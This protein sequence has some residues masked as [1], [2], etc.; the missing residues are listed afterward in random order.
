VKTPAKL[1]TPEPSP[2]P[3]PPPSP[4]WMG[5]HVY[6]NAS[7]YPY[8]RQFTMGRKVKNEIDFLTALIRLTKT[9]TDESIFQ[10]LMILL[11]HF[12]RDD[13]LESMHVDLLNNIVSYSP[14]DFQNI[15]KL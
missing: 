1:P 14:V 8:L 11:E 5:I 6:S 3:R 10:D 13:V 4:E 12:Y 2:E 9:L 7:W 15:K